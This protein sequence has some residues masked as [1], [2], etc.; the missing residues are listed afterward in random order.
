MSMKKQ[1]IPISLSIL[2][3]LTIGAC[4]KD[5]GNYTYT[6]SNA[7]SITTDMSA[8]DPLVVITNDSLVIKEN[9]TLKLDVI[10][11]QKIPS[12][13]LSY[14][15]MITQTVAS[16]SNPPQYVVGTAKQLRAKILLSPNLYRLVLRVTDNKTGVSYYK[17]YNLNVDT[18]PWGGEGWLVLQ[19]QPT[20][21]GGDISLIASRDGVLRGT[22]Y[23]NLY[24]TANSHKLVTG[25]NKIAVMNYNNTI[26]I[27]K[28]SLFS[29]ASGVQVRSVDYL[30][31]SSH[32]GWFFLPPT[33]FNMQANA[34]ASAT[35]Q[36]EYMINNGQV[37]TQT[38]N[39]LT[40]KTPPI[41]FGAP[42]LGSWPE[43]SPYVINNS[44]SDN[45]YTL[46]DKANRCFLLLNV[47]NNT[48]VP[49]A[50]PDVPNKHFVNYAGTPADLSATGKGFDM[51]NVNRNLIYA[52]NAQTSTSASTYYNAIFR[53]TTG[54][55]TFL[56]QFLAGI[57]YLNNITT[58]R[59]LL[60]ETLVPGI[61]TA[62]IF[63][64]PTFLSLPGGAFYYVPG[65]NANA[66]YVCNPSYTGTL[67]A[68]TTSHLGYSFPSGT[69]VKS[70]KVFKSGYTT[71]ALPATEGKVLV[72]AT[73]ES[74]NSNGNNVYFLNLTA[75]GDI[76]ST[77]ANVY[78][79]FDKI[80]DIAFKKGL[81][82]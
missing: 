64:V 70:M 80:V 53:N 59:Y 40:I 9:D 34:V 14:Q 57:A 48:L 41:K 5:L 29:P 18:S 74:A 61:N 65:T 30:D 1:I 8:A 67:P 79:G 56:Y 23:N 58:G 13:D 33:A 50:Q 54:D 26:R 45:Y 44:T 12:T 24:F 6:D 51:N 28:I 4:K 46:F 69:I 72:V 35:G 10:L 78:T 82:L 7:I 32:L 60:K 16:A 49:A 38:V 37:C 52:E 27:Q 19:D 66:I 25:T 71:T 62:T 42:V 77:P 21:S 11:T 3:L 55:S 47:S 36:Y 76:V 39:A 73:D 43:L 22:V 81:G 75:A 31:S 2:I 68:T 20:Q 63:A 17:F 15:W